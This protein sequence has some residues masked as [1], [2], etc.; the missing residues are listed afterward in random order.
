MQIVITGGTGIVGRPTA[1][2]LAAR[3]HSVT[4]LS[5]A[6]LDRPSSAP[7]VT[8]VG[9]NPVTGAGLQEAVEGADVVIHLARTPLPPRW[10]DEGWHRVLDARIAMLNHLAQAIRV[11]QAPPVHLVCASSHDYYGSHSSSLPLA[12]ETPP[13]DDRMACLYNLIERAAA[14]ARPAGGVLTCA[15]IGVVLGPE[16]LNPRFVVHVL[17]DPN[18]P[19]SWIHV[20]DVG[21]MLVA[22]VEQKIGGPVNLTAPVSTTGRQVADIAKRFTSIKQNPPSGGTH[23]RLR[24]A[25]AGGTTSPP[26]ARVR[27]ED[28]ETHILYQPHW[29][30]PAAM[31]AHGYRWAVP[32]IEQ[33]LSYLEA[34]SSPSASNASLE[35]SGILIS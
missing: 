35:G 9:W 13:G 3:G 5:R 24:S 15:R 4:V 23:W 32:S 16:A 20:D 19:L 21:A 7:G 34:K 1:V 6:G 28:E 30:Y 27:D 2:A 31:V 26:A 10:T 29:A 14:G 17:A 18:G 11:A 8:V 22:I 12:E 33:A 25:F